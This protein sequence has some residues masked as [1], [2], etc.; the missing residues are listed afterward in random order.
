M[1]IKIH[2]IG[3]IKD[4][5]LKQ[6][7][8][9]Y[10]LKIRKYALVEIIEYEDYPIN[11]NISDE[12]IKNKECEKVLSKLKNSDF[13]ITLDLNKVEYTSEQFADLLNDSF[14][15]GGSTINFLIG[16]SL[17]LSK[18]AKQRSNLSISLSKMTFLHGMTRLILL[19][20]IYRA[21][22]INNNE[23]YHK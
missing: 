4:K 16:G 2:A 23:V 9:E 21:F 22:K 17:G 20:Q 3:K 6:G 1:N 7:I 19:E 14:I 15:K 12:D 13:L 10:L 5:Y 11:K 18:E 8:N